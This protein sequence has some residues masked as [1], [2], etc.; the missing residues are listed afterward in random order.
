MCKTVFEV[1]LFSIENFALMNMQNKIYW[2]S[3]KRSIES[4]AV[5][6]LNCGLWEKVDFFVVGCNKL[7][8]VYKNLFEN[9]D[10]VVKC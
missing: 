3:L 5:G 2:C 4:F 10:P 7:F 1:F 6:F 8:G 9:K